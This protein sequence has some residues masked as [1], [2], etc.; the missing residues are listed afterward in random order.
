[1]RARINFFVDA[2]FSKCSS[3]MYPVYKMDSLEEK[4]EECKKW[5]AVIEKEIEPLLKDAKPYFGGNDKMTLAEVSSISHNM[6]G[7]ADIV[8]RP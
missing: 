1:M 5:S 6:K 4:Q 8:S 7:A 2:W 3:F